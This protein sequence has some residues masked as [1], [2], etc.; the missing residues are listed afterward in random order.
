MT[1]VLL[2]L[3]LLGPLGDCARDGRAIS[4]EFRLIDA[5]PPQAVNT[6][7]T[8]KQG[9]PEPEPATCQPADPEEEE[10]V[11]EILPRS[12]TPVVRSSLGSLT[13]R[14]I[15]WAA[16]WLD[17]PQYDGGYCGQDWS[18][19]GW[20]G[21]LI[22]PV[23]S[24][25]IPT[26]DD[27]TRSRGPLFEEG[28]TGI[29][30][31]GPAGDPVVAPASGRIVYAGWGRYTGN[32]VTISHGSGRFSTLI[33]LDEVLIQCGQVVEVGQ[34]VGTVGRTG[35]ASFNHVHFEVQAG[36]PGRLF[37]LTAFDPMAWLG[38]N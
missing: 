12:F 35:G 22:T 7:N 28:H 15:P 1:A 17:P 6:V 18:G 26:E 31:S 20:S 37:G 8:V 14:S 13:A 27:P 36:D 10:P 2:V 30:I 32:A 34:Q 3:C 38:G 19:S 23:P 21:Y 5:R 16:I 33:H 29:D 25:T 4:A 11:A 9:D 24:G